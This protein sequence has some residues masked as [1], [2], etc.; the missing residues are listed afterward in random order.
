M[1]EILA[2]SREAND[3]VR[4]GRRILE[5]ALSGTARNPNDSVSSWY[6]VTSPRVSA[7]EGRA[8]PAVN[9]SEEQQI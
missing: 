1:A 6:S 5:F 3:S 9:F 8:L 2:P 7:D 4:P